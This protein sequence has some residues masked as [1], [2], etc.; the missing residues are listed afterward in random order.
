MKKILVIQPS[1]AAAERVFSLLNFGFVDLQENSLKDY[2][3]A[4]I[5]LRYNH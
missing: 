3:E 1:S 2:T 4:S 5:M